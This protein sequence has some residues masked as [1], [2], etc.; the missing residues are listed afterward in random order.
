MD[1][2]YLEQ[3]IQKLPA[4]EQ[5]AARAAFKAISETGDDGPLSKLF[6]VLRANNEYAATIPKELVVAGEKLLRELDARAAQ[7][8][9]QNAEADAQREKRI[10]EIIAQQ[11]PQ[12]GKA[13]ALDRVATG[14]DAQTAELGRI[15]S[16][17]SRLRHLRVGGLLLLMALGGLVGSSAVVGIY[18]HPF[19]AAEQAGKFVS[20]LNAAGVYV[21]IK[22]AE[23]GGTLVTV[24]GAPVL[25]GTA[26]RKNSDNYTTGADFYFPKGDNR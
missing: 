14:L 24:E 6:V 16:T 17:L 25:H 3:L 1:E 8:A 5:T 12:L 23:N 13:L 15:E 7:L 20:R 18:W 10:G 2:S 26:W 11:V 19:H 9:K 4:A 21:S 22:D